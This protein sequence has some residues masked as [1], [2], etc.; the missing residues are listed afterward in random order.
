MDSMLTRDTHPAS[1]SVPP[2]SVVAAAFLI[3]NRFA[4]IKRISFRSRTAYMKHYFMQADAF[5]LAVMADRDRAQNHPGSDFM[6]FWYSMRKIL[7]LLLGLPIFV[8]CAVAAEEQLQPLP[9]PVSNNAVAGIKVNGQLLVYSMT[10][11][12]SKKTWDSVTN[13]AYA[14]NVKYDTWTAI[15]PV[16]GSGR[17]GATAAGVKEQVFLIGGYVPDPQGEQAIVPDV[18]IYEPVALRWYR[19]AELPIAVRDSVSGVYKDRY[20]YVIGGFSKNGPTNQV[21]LYD[22]ETDKWT[23]ATPSPGLPVFGHSGGIVNDSIVYVG[24]A[25]ASSGKPGF[26]PS[27]EAW[28]GKIDRKDP[29]KIEW[30]KLPLPPSAA[31]YR[32]AAGASEKDQRI[33]FAGGSDKVYE[34]NGIGLD[35]TPAEPSPV[36]FAYNVKGSAWETIQQNAPTPS[37]DHRGMAV[38]SDGL[39]IVGGMVSG[40]KVVASVELLPKSK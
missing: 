20:V 8:M 3:L 12:G 4:Q 14:L 26:T 36:T 18:S 5:F 35:G 2:I 19:G 21:Q 25:V 40:Q 23:S 1:N 7:L 24:G 32:I 22:S 38:S 10:G 15:K 33:Y 34:F 28:M 9:V 31:R 13:A 27:D 16:P 37:M 30:S 6:V 29:R 17:L 39:I 11:I